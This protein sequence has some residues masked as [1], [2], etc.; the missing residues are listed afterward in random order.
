MAGVVISVTGV[1]LMHLLDPLLPQ[2]DIMLQ[3]SYLVWSLVTREVSY[4]VPGP[5]KGV[6]LF[7]LDSRFARFRESQIM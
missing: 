5:S 4:L 2:W 6:Q 1:I 3:L 7:C